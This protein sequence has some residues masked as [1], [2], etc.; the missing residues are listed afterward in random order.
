MKKQMWFSTVVAVIASLMLAACA[1][2][3][4]APVVEAPAC[5]RNRS[6]GGYSSN[7]SAGG[8][9]RNRNTGYRST[10]LARHHVRGLGR[11]LL[12]R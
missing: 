11:P 9:S 10:G 8:C 7:R 6:T 1:A 5:T 12:Q 2:P 4:P 3:A